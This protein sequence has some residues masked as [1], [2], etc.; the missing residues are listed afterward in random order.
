VRGEGWRDVDDARGGAG[1]RD[2]LVH[3]VEYRQPEMLC[4]GFFRRHAADHLRPVGER[5]LR[6]DCTGLS[7]HPLGDDLGVPVDEDAPGNASS[8]RLF[9]ICL[10]A[11]SSSLTAST[12][13]L[14]F[15]RAAASSSISTIRST[16]SAPITHGTP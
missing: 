10:H 3:R 6:V 4:P 2:R 15:W 7:G 13:T 5:L 11:S 14:K 1:F 12:L 9:S 16:P 8:A